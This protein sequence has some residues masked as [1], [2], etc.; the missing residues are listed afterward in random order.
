MLG[1]ALGLAFLS[2]FGLGATALVIWLGLGSLTLARRGLSVGAVAAIGVVTLLGALWAHASVPG[3]TTLFSADAFEGVLLVDDGPFLTRSGQRLLARAERVPSVLLCVYAG[4]DPRPLPG[5]RIF[6]SGEITQMADLSDLEAAAARTKGCGAQ[7]RIESMHVIGRGEGI[8]ARVAR[9]RVA[10]SDWLMRVAP[11]DAGALLSGLVTGDDGGLSRS[12]NRAF[13]ASGTTHI[14]AI[15][16][17]NFATLTLLL[18]VLA[19][20]SMRRNVLFVA[21]ASIV[22]W[23]YAI[24]V[25]LEPSAFRAALLA[26]AVLVGRWIGRRPDLLTLTILLAAIQI[27]VR[28]TDFATLAF[29]LSLA[30]TV[31]LIIVF[32]GVE[33]TDRGSWWA[34]LGLAVLAAQLA[35]IPILAW[36]LGT[37]TGVGVLANL[38]V[39]PL[40]GLAFPIALLGALIGRV[41]PIVGE[42]IV[43]PAIWI[44]QLM[45]FF[46]EWC[47]RH[48]PGIV[49]LGDPTPV[50]MVTI[51]LVCWLA[52]VWLSGDLR[53][54]GRHALAVVR[55]W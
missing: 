45:L 40:A 31:A 9:E 19:T 11:G 39:G 1:L 14:T 4:P 15:S 21:G 23:L 25:G 49:Q 7:L 22:I 18:G 55:S 32:D 6:A 17:A 37:M 30:A 54:L 2:G 34:N 5:D 43:L 3:P 8:G 52:V 36:T 28:P 24:M 27:V 10:L 35:T 44:C 47:D 42:I 16:G 20:G 33:W 13:L 29:Q 38:V 41:L 50:G 53:R 48:L 12:A 46:V 51:T 26:T